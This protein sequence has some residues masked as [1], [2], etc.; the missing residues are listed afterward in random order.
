M[1]RITRSQYFLV[2]GFFPLLFAIVLCFTDGI[3]IKSILYTLPFALIFGPI[4]IHYFKKDGDY[5]TFFL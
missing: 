2:I 5:A 3:D 4:G 1:G